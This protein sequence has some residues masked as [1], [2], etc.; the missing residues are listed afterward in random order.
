MMSHQVPTSTQEAMELARTGATEA[1]REGL[2][3]GLSAN[4]CDDQGQTLLMLATYHG[5][6]DTAAL[7]LEHGAEVDRRNHHGQT[8]LGGAAYKG[9]ASLVRLLIEHG[10][11]PEA[12][13]GGGHRPVAFA[14]MA[15]HRDIATYLRTCSGKKN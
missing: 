14:E 3:A 7:L 1:L 5:H 10:A 11:D 8:P 12:D 9:F 4:H 13:Q 15:G 2:A 6:V